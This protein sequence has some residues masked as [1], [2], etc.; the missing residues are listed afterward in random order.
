[1]PYKPR[2]HHGLS[3][4]ASVTLPIGKALY[5]VPLTYPLCGLEAV[6]TVTCL[7]HHVCFPF[8]PQEIMLNI[9]K[10]VNR[11]FLCLVSP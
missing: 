8:S 6:Y 3:P 9:S 2:S 10:S 7:A 4:L 5:I 11:V 1:M